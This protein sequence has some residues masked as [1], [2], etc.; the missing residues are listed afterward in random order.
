MLWVILALMC[1]AAIG[2]TVW[3][4]RRNRSNNGLLT[5]IAVLA[6]A[7]L[8]A[9]VYWVTGEPGVPSGAGD[10][11][12]QRQDVPELGAMV[13]SLAERLEREPDDLEGWKMLGRSY[14]TLGNAEGAIA[15]WERAVEVSSGQDVGALV[16]LGEAL[17]ATSGQTM[18]PRSINSSANLIQVAA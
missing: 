4:L 13:A 2:F 15:A 6:V 11:L 8:S 10:P 5:G 1:L 17:L 7:S 14:T 3:P 16:G 18:T 9:G 12:A